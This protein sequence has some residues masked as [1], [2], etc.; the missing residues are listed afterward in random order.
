[1]TEDP[2]TPG[3]PSPNAPRGGRGP[4]ATDGDPAL[5][6]TDGVPEFHRRGLLGDPDRKDP[7]RRAGPGARRLCGPRPVALAGWI[8]AVLL[9]L[10]VAAL[11]VATGQVLGVVAGL[12][13]VAVAS[14]VLF[15]VGSARVLLDGTRLHTRTPVGWTPILDLDRLTTV[16]LVTGIPRGI[17]RRRARPLFVELADADGVAT[18]IDAANIDQAPLLREVGARVTSRGLQFDATTRKAVDRAG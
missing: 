5:A 1:M 16:R 3:G 8:G 13:L 18:R 6:S 12:L 10:A 15:V 4:G 14:A 11:S 7:A 9:G 2:G 17:L